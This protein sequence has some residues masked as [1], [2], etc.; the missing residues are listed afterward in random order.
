MAA[1]RSVGKVAYVA[2]GNELLSGRTVNE[3]GRYLARAL[4]Q[5]GYEIGL[6]LTVGDDLSEIEIALEQAT[7]QYGLVFTSGGLGPTSDDRTREALTLWANRPVVTSAAAKQRIV[8]RLRSLGRAISEGHHRQAMI[9]KGSTLLQN[10][11]GAAAGFSFQK[12]RATVIV[13]P[14]VPQEFQAMIDRHLNRHLKPLKTLS[15]VT[16]WRV[17]GMTESTVAK[18]IEPTPDDQVSIAYLPN[19]SHLDLIIRATGTD[20]R[21][22]KARL[23]RYLAKAS[24]K[25]GSVIVTDDGRLLGEIVVDLF[26]QAGLTVSVAESCTGGLVSAD[27]TA[28]AGSSKIFRS[29]VVSYSNESKQELLGVPM[30][31]IERH[32]AVSREVAQAMA[33]G[34]RQGA[35]VGL[36]VT[37]VAGPDG[38]TVEKPVGLVWIALAWQGGCVAHSVR[39]PG[40]REIIRRLATSRALDWL[41][42]YAMGLFDEP[43][44]VAT[45]EG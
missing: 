42:R 30:A 9:L 6:I 16:A 39:F 7:K 32:G 41:R 2:I 12:N 34:V 40:N 8:N 27:L 33:I 22:V 28:V 3:N 5:R 29:G 36:A 20:R 31:L 24:A 4:I 23:E 18:L 44:F 38:G 26:Q 43:P 1:R 37:G 21:Q 45:P 17:V 35:D 19:M 15:L 10:P 25:L 14:G 11:T 13:L